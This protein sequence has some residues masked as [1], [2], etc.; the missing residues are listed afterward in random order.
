[1]VQLFH[2]AAHVLLHSKKGVFV[3][4]INGNGTEQETEANEWASNILVPKPAWD[5]FA[6]SLP[7]SVHTVRE[8]A[9]EQGIAPGI[10]VGMLQHKGLL[11]W[12]HLNSLKVR[13]NRKP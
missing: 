1:M 3:D 12:T 6:S 9:D 5:Q 2:E 7:K 10:V 4:D 8:F 11:P 13:L